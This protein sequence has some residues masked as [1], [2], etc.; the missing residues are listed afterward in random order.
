MFLDYL[1]LV[2]L[3]IGLT[4]VFYTF[5]Y[6]HDLPYDIAKHREHPH[7]EAIHVA[8]W[9]SLFTLHAIWP[10]VFIWAVSHKKHVG[11]VQLIALDASQTELGNRLAELERRLKNLEGADGKANSRVEKVP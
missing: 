10:I 9:L 8:C 6:I 2:V 7:E 11:G 4:L 1:A 3:L 5:I